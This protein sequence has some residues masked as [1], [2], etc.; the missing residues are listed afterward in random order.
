[1]IKSDWYLNELS[2]LHEQLVRAQDPNTVE[3][4]ESSLSVLVLYHLSQCL[5]LSQSFQN[6]Q[7]GDDEFL[8]V[9]QLEQAASEVYS[10]LEVF[11]C[12][13]AKFAPVDCPDPMKD[14]KVQ[15]L[16]LHER[17]HLRRRT[18]PRFYLRL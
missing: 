4:D 2:D 15:N 16:L 12:I 13:V 3:E 10:I 6:N 11:Y 8:N 14:S 9:T 17:H 7:K 5:R 18:S 1:M